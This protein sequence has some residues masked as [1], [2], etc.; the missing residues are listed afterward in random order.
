MRSIVHTFTWALLGTL[1]PTLALAQRSGRIT[2]SRPGWLGIRCNV[3]IEM[4]NG[5]RAT[6][7]VDVGQVLAGSPA[8]QS[9]LK[10]G[11]RILRIDGRALAQD[12]CG[13]LGRDIEVGDTV[14]LQ[15]QDGDRVREVTIIAAERPPEYFNLPRSPLPEDFVWSFRGDSVRRMMR[16][17][18]DSAMVRID[19]GFGDTLIFRDG[20]ARGAL[21]FKIDSLGRFAPFGDTLSG[22]IRL[23]MLPGVGELLPFDLEHF[24]S[25]SH[26]SV[27]GAE[28]AAV[29]PGLARLTGT[30]EG[31]LVTNVAPG[32]PASRAGL[33]SGD[34]LVR[35]NGQPVD[36]V[37]DFRNAI[38]RRGEQPLKLEVVRNRKTITLEFHR[39]RVPRP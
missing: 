33:E 6:V 30:D 3:M 35:V 8:E 15:L 14:R 12:N 36:E 13:D 31:L 20:F 10:R 37:A 11:D 32:T 1:I 38:L 34:V 28:F 17:Q 27:G 18:L 5:S 9:G 39:T 24:E 21:G 23:R 22:G 25:L 4:R 7:T 16:L 29:N 26:R 19:R 2:E